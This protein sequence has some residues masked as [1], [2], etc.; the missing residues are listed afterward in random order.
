MFASNIFK[1]SLVIIIPGKRK[2]KK[3][4]SKKCWKSSP[5]KQTQNYTSFRDNENIFLLMNIRK[6]LARIIQ[7][8][9]I[10]IDGL[11][12]RI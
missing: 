2:T 7:K 10:E 9:R 1:G 11:A 5:T 8:C 6:N 4:S 3:R 12:Y